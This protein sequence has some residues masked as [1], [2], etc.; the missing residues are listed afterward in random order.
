M[1]YVKQQ[2]VQTAIQ[3]VLLYRERSWEEEEHLV[4]LEV[5]AG[6]RKKGCTVHQ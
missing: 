6:Q 4:F 2:N 5:L 1:N 3:L